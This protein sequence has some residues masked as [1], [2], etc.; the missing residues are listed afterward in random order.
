MTSLFGGARWRK[1]D[2][3]I[4]LYN[5]PEHESLNLLYGRIYTVGEDY[6]FSETNQQIKN[7]KIK[8]S[9]PDNRQH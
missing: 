4:W 7:L 2:A 6:S 9:A 3:S 8:P 5:C 1:T